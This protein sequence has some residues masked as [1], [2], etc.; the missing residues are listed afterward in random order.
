MIIKQI[1]LTNFKCFEKAKFE[2]SDL[3]FIKGENGSGK[4]TIALDSVLYCLFGYYKGDL[5]SD[6]VRRGKQGKASVE[7]ILEHNHRV[8]RVIRHFPTKLTIKED[9]KDLKFV[10]TTD[11]QNWI[12]KT[13]GDRLSFVR[14]RLIDTATQDTNFLETGQT[15]IKKILFSATDEIFNNIKNKLNSIKSE[16]ER[17]CKDK[18]VTYTHYPSEKRLQLISSKL[19]ELNNN[20]R[21]MDRDIISSERELRTL[22]LGVSKNESRQSEVHRTIIDLQKQQQKLQE[23]TEIVKTQKKC[24]ACKQ[25]LPDTSAKEI[26]KDKDKEIAEKQTKVELLTKESNEL[27]HQL[28]ELKKEIKNMSEIITQDK[29][30]RDQFL[31]KKDKLNNL[32]MKL[33]TRI[34]Q[35]EFKY[36]QKDV[37]IVKRAIGE[38][39]NLSTYY[40]LETVRILEPII[41]SVLEKIDFR[42]KFETNDKGKFEI[43]LE[44]QGI[45]YKYKDLSTG[46]KLLLQVAF[47]LAL[48]LEQNKTGVIIA[49]E[50]LGSLDEKN[51]QHILQL[52]EN[53]P[54]QL[55]MVLH[56]APELSENIKIIDLNKKEK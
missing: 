3:T 17:F 6:I 36:T 38:V 22:E 39:D 11:A 30:V 8:Y 51:L 7:V 15:T 53:Y 54:F 1:I 32:K 13:F 19:N 47:K 48:L 44:R 29:Q 40:L 10:N 26:I 52:F 43:H 45:L 27:L 50:G 34:K 31:P 33:E 12:N 24:Y 25:P 21:E 46:Q 14:F 16:R 37:E 9:D 23:N 5:L 41:N 28:P 2:F 55:V 20:Y 42:V 18:A 4:S 49:D 56:R 35:K